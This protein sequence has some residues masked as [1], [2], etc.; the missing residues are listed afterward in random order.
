MALKLHANCC[1]LAGAQH[2]PDVIASLPGLSTFQQAAEPRMANLSLLM[3]LECL[4]GSKPTERCREA[5]WNREGSPRLTRVHQLVPSL[6]PEVGH[7]IFVGARG[8]RLAFES[9]L[10]NLG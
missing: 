4:Q 7:S 1:E 8:H 10:S 9:L 3:A 6:G 5:R 2:Q